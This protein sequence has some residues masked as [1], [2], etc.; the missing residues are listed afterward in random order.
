M[1]TGPLAGAAPLLLVGAGK[2]GGAMLERW[3]AS[4]L[5]PRQVTI[6]D[7]YI[8][9]EQKAALTGAG[10]LVAGSA[11][12]IEGGFSLLVLAVKP[13]SMAD[14][15]PAVRPLSSAATAIVSVAAGIRLETLAAGFAPGQ[16]IVRVMPNTP[17]QV[18]MGMSVGVGNAELSEEQRAVVAALF[19]A[20]G[21]VAWVDDEAQMDAVTAVSGSGPAYVFL[22][23]ECLA[24]AGRQAG[25][26][27]ELAELLGRQTV[28]GAGALLAESPLPAGLLR[29]NVTSPKGTTAAALEVLMAGD[30]LQPLLTRAVAAAKRRSVELG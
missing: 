23:A 18:G 2:M 22:L 14:V 11:G 19:A 7:P 28:A 1:Q 26:P 21:K 30:G 5:D 16:P 27:A 10:V 12:E 4:G 29:Q 17:A 24:E 8:A 15:L 6:L 3:L 20:I 9:A 25:L 13:Q